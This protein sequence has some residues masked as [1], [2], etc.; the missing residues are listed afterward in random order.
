MKDKELKELISQDSALMQPF[1]ECAD[2][3]PSANASRGVEIEGLILVGV[4]LPIAK[5]ILI[6]FGLPWLNGFKKWHDLKLAAFYQSVEVEFKEKGLD[7]GKVD[8]VGQKM[9]DSLTKQTS[10][11][12]KAAWEALEKKVI[13]SK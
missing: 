4:L 5:Y 7:P 10:P 9:Y 11:A 3:F 8:E 2:S 13:E 12:S 1:E 6:N